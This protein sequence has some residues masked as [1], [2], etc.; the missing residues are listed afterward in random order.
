VEEPIDPGDLFSWNR[1]E[2]GDTSPSPLEPMTL[3]EKLGAD[4][5][6]TGLTVGPHPMA[7]VR[8]KLPHAWRASDLPQVKHGDWITIAGNVICRQRPG[9]AKGFV[10]LSLEDETGIANAIVPPKLFEQLRLLITQESFLVVSGRAQN[11]N[12]VILIR[13]A[14][15]ES[16]ESVTAGQL[17]GA[18][19]HD[20][21]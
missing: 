20:F 3:P 16:M 2:Q 15:V 8:E 6:G 12:K 9:T 18:E 11:W 17:R 13:A 4:Y 5:E 19:S 10:F 7:L 14:E 1:T 21:H